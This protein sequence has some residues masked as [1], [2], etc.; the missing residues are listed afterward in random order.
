M[1]PDSPATRQAHPEQTRAAT[2]ATFRKGNY[3]LVLASTE[4]DPDNPFNGGYDL[5][6]ATAIVQFGFT[7]ESADELALKIENVG[8]QEVLSNVALEDAAL[9]KRIWKSSVYRPA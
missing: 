6:V 2:L 4:G 5:V 8:P 3:A 7:P 1:K 9:V